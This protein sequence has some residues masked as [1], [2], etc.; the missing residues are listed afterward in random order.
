[1]RSHSLLPNNFTLP[2][3]LKASARSADSILGIKLHALVAKL[4][5]DRDVFVRTGLVSL[6]AKCGRLEDARKVFDE[7]SEKNT[8][9]W[10]AIISGF[11]DSRMFHEAVDMFRELLNSGLKPDGFTI[12]RVLS[13]CAHLGDS[14]T[15][16]W[17]DQYVTA[18]NGM[19]RN[20]FISTALV[21]MYAK[22][23]NMER[24]QSVFKSMPEKDIVSWSAM[25]QGYASNG[26]PKEA[27]DMFFRMLDENT[28]P[29]CYATVGML[30]ACARLGALGLGE[31]VRDLMGRDEFLDNP[32]LGTALIDMYAKCGAIAQA[33][34]VFQ[35]MRNKDR[36]V[37]NAAISGLAM[38]GHEKAVFGLFGL[39]E[40]LRIIPDQNTFMGLLCACTHAGLVRDGRQYFYSM[41]RVYSVSPTIEHYGCLVDLLGR[42]G[43]LD[44]A[45][46]LIRSMPME[47][48]TIIWGALLGGC[49]MHRHTQL[50]EL[51]VKKL[52]ELEPWNS[53]NYVLLSNIYSA[54][55]RWDDAAEVRSRMNNEGICK[56]PGSSWVEVGGTVH[57]FHVGDKSHPSWEKIYTKLDELVREMR[58]LGYVP[59]TEYVLFD[60]EEE[61]KW[62]FLG[63]HSEKL[64]V[65]FALLSTEDEEVIRVVKNLRVCGDCH[66]AMKLISRIT[67]RE[68]IVRDN[69]RF[70]C[71][72]D[73]SCSCKDYW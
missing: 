15:G 48:N 5:F 50:G 21:D 35:E 3:V 53:G 69:N 45:H 42:A 30:N 67:G 61:E 25:I 27:I 72:R 65:A 17:I 39:M 56:V 57:E 68:I 38:N 59:T 19:G 1:M 9:S 44:E 36:V 43:E 10:A 16:E 58:V 40:K 34:K 47:A 12:V 23:G 32:V 70:H 66:A 22:C 54:S 7:I 13:A 18:E 14:A 63:W 29:D 41:D 55:R 49:R 64:A 4:G 33:W 62:Q 71:F 6:Y 2:F 11:I 8:V 51:A 46:R 60:I 28:R 20:L 24:A 26:L 73:G 31:W 52:I 37:W